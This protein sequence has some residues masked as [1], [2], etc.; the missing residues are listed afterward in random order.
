VLIEV[1]PTNVYPFG[2]R[3][4]PTDAVVFYLEYYDVIN[5]KVQAMRITS[6]GTFTWAPFNRTLSSVSS[7][8]VHPE[9]NEFNSNQWICAW[10]D[11]RNDGNR[12]IYAQ[13]IQLEGILGPW[14]PQIGTITGTVSL[15]GGTASVTEVHVSAAGVTVHPDAAGFYTMDVPAGIWNVTASLLG[16]YPDTVFS[17]AVIDE[18]TTSGVDM[19]LEAMPTGFIDGTVLLDG[20]QGN[21]ADV[22]IT[23]WY[24][25]ASPDANGD[26]GMEVEAGT[27]DVTASLEGY[28]TGI[29]PAVVVTEDETTFNVD[30]TLVPVPTTGLITG[31]VELENDAGD[32]AQVVVSSGGVAISPDSTGFYSL[33]VVAGTWDVSA[34]LE[35]FYTQVI[36]GVV[37]VAGETTPDIDFFLPQ[38]PDVGYVSGYVILVNGTGDVTLSEVSAGGEITHPAVNGHYY[39]GLPP[40]TYTVLAT[41]PYA[42]PDSTEDISIIAGETSEGVDFELEIARTDMVCKAFDNY[43]EVLH[44]VDVEITGPEATYTGTITGDS[45]VFLNVPYGL[46]DGAGFHEDI[47]M[48]VSS[49]EIGPGNHEVIFMFTW[50]G[51]DEQEESGN[52]FSVFPNPLG[53]QLGML[54]SLPAGGRMKFSLHSVTGAELWASDEEISTSGPQTMTLDLKDLPRGVYLLKLSAGGILLTKV[55][56]KP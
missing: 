36:Q 27:Y 5:A 23:V 37:V 47:G 22:V 43:G 4:S 7:E 13:N 31:I 17:V 20:G 34:S 52:T 40:G 41:H 51:Q 48:V 11:T 53:D 49:A 39:L 54:Y 25:T 2:A 3:S 12:D 29:I 21:V 26:Y 46:Y 55:L 16:Y 14:D 50:V 42:M 56:L 24:H 8:K 19:S 10:E 1:G 30:F 6:S 38:I 33:E 32:V 15:V 45:L 9:V 18:E 35:G 44:D 28:V